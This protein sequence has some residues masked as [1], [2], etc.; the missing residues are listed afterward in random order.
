MAKNNPK[1]GDTKRGKSGDTY[2]MQS[3][4]TWQNNRTGKSY[5]LNKLESILFNLNKDLTYRAEQLS[6]EDF[7]YIS[8]NI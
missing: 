1:P 7:V 6:I 3:D 8:N 2:T 5:D 4:G